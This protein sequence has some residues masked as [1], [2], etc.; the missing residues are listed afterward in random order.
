MLH[1]SYGRI[2]DGQQNSQ[3]I[4]NINTHKR[5]ACM[6]PAGFEPAILASG[7]QQTHS[8]HHTGTGI[9]L[10]GIC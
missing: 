7:W 3:A 9:G 6:H 2:R 8:L 5:L 10:P 4:G 1:N